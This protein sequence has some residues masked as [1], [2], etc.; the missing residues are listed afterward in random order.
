[1]R[2]REAEPASLER[3]F[4]LLLSRMAMTPAERAQLGRLLKIAFY[5]GA[6][7][8]HRRVVLG[9]ARCRTDA[10]APATLDALAAELREFVRRERRGR[11]PAED[12]PEPV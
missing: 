8:H 1:M 6:A 9:L 5:G 4:D 2:N 12:E 7:A 10:Q 11:P 3:E